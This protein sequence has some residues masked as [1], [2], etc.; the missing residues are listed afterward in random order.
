MSLYEDEMLRHSKKVL[1]NA[2]LLFDGHCQKAAKYLGFHRNTLSRQ[3]AIAGVDLKEIKLAIRKKRTRGPYEQYLCRSVD[4][5]QR[6]NR[7]AGAGA[8]VN[9]NGHEFRGSAGIP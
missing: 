4:A 5:P 6:D 1:S 8:S 7:P 9:A 2:L 3:M